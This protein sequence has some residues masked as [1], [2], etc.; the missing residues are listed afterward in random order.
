MN[1]LRRLAPEYTISRYPDVTD[2]LPYENY[3][4]EIASEQ[5]GRAEEVLKWLKLKIK[6]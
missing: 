6:E 1:F 4:L 5:L 2:T 3:N